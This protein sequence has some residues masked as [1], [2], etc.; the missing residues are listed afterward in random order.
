MRRRGAQ[1]DHILID[2]GRFQEAPGMDRRGS[3]GLCPPRGE[4]VV[5]EEAAKVRSRIEAEV[6][7]PVGAQELVVVQRACLVAPQLVVYSLPD[8]VDAL[9][10][11]VSRYGV[12][13]GVERHEV[14]EPILEKLQV[15]Q[16]LPPVV[17]RLEGDVDVEVVLNGVFV[18]QQRPGDLQVHLLKSTG[19]IRLVELH[20]ALGE[21]LLCPSQVQRVKG[22][23][24]RA[25]GRFSDD[26]VA[27]ELAAGVVG[28]VAE[29]VCPVEVP[30]MLPDDV[31]LDG[32]V[33][34]ESLRDVD[35]PVGLVFAKTSLQFDE[36]LEKEY[37]SGQALLAVYDVVGAMGVLLHEPAFFLVPVSEVVDGNLPHGDEARVVRTAF[38]EV[39]QVVPEL[40]ELLRLP[41][42]S[43]LVVRNAKD[44]VVEEHV[45]GHGLHREDS[46]WTA[47]RAVGSSKAVCTAMLTLT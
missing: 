21:V 17:H 47:G 20:Q 36:R 18:E 5:Q 25:D 46:C 31:L 3:G 37:K 35:L 40:A 34:G 44:L 6:H 1:A 28:I 15:R 42:E 8:L 33:Y 43:T 32:V 23:V 12:Q 39:D 24:D 38:G 30:R 45:Q 29:L 41:R 2:L 10:E 4:V 19:P 9:P 14:D 27:E 22:F 16:R 26:L 13:V 7:D 11:V